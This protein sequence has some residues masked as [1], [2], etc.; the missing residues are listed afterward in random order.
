MKLCCGPIGVLGVFDWI[1]LVWGLDFFGGA[2][3]DLWRWI[4]ARSV[5]FFSPLLASA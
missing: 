1:E 5:F 2:K 4:A 3:R